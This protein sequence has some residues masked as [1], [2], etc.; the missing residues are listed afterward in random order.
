MG[1]TVNLLGRIR[2][3]VLW[4]LLHSMVIT[5]FAICVLAGLD[6]EVADDATPAPTET[7]QENYAE[8][9]VTLIAQIAVAIAVLGRKIVQSEAKPVT[10]SF[11]K[12]LRP[13][14]MAIITMVT[15]LVVIGIC[16]L[17]KAEYIVT[18]SISTVTALV[19]LSSDII[20][21][22]NEDT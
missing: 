2:P 4:A 12:R 22:E 13:T 6:P 17:P 7:G 19:G 1:E 21:A 18:I 3:T 16:K 9:I 5:I 10:T 14:V 8:H 20:E 11:C 15:V